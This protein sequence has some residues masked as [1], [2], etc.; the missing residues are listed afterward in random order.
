[1][2]HFGPRVFGSLSLAKTRIGLGLFPLALSFP[3]IPSGLGVAFLVFDCAVVTGP[4][5]SG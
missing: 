3:K 2:I 5:W 1:L 4:C